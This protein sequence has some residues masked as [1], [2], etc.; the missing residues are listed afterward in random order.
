LN[1]RDA[2]GG[3]GK[4]TI[5]TANAALAIPAA[6]ARGIAPGDYV[7]I[8]VIDAG[9]GMDEATLARAFDPFF[10]TKEPGKGT[11]LGL[12]MV[13]G[14]IQQSRGHVKIY[15]EVGQGTTMKLY[16]PR[17]RAEGAS[18]SDA[19]PLREDVAAPD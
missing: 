8:S 14:F 7:K 10:T 3:A 17:L 15:S 1:A 13:F 19:R 2:M 18:T 6:R 16:L 9:C 12:S 4:L 11:G 5:A